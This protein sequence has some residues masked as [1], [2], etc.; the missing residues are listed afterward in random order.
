MSRAKAERAAV[1]KDLAQ[2]TSQVREARAEWKSLRDRHGDFEAK[3]EKAEAEWRQRMR[4]R[5]DLQSEVRR[6]A[7]QARAGHAASDEATTR[8]AVAKD[9][10]QRVQMELSDRT[11][12][13]QE[14][15]K[16]RDRLH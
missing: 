11:N 16:V 8:A 6:L 13:R 3:A 14:V 10:L 7:D 15:M 5:D 12:E 4:Q 9:E 1:E 2:L